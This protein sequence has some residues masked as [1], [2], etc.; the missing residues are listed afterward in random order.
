M[1]C[2]SHTANRLC[3]ALPPD[4]PT[5]TAPFDSPFYQKA[6]PCPAGATG[7]T[8]ST[9]GHTYGWDAARRHSCSFDKP[10]A[11]PLPAGAA[12]LAAPAPRRGGMR[13]SSPRPA[14]NMHMLSMQLP[15]VK[16]LARLAP[17]ANPQAA[18]ALIAAPALSMPAGKTQPLL[19]ARPLDASGA[20]GG[21][22]TGVSLMPPV[23]EPLEPLQTLRRTVAAPLPTAAAPVPRAVTLPAASPLAGPLKPS[24]WDTPVPDV[25]HGAGGPAHPRPSAP[26]AD[27]IAAEQPAELQPATMATGIMSVAR[28]QAVAA[29]AVA[30]ATG[31]AA[32]ILRAVDNQV[33]RGLG[34]ASRAPCADGPVHVHVFNRSLCACVL[35]LQAGC[36]YWP[37]ECWCKPAEKCMARMLHRSFC[38]P[39]RISHVLNRCC[40][41]PAQVRKALSGHA[42]RNATGGATH[43]G[44]AAAHSNATATPNSAAAA[45]NSAAVAAGEGAAKEA[46]DVGSGGGSGA[47]EG[48]V[49][50]KATA[51]DGG[52]EGPASTS[53]ADSG[54]G[55]LSRS[56]GAAA[57]AKGRDATAALSANDVAA[58]PAAPAA[59]AVMV[60][61][62][63]QT[64]ASGR[65]RPSWAASQAE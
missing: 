47:A 43:A 23:A 60:M 7:P 15:A 24:I 2:A 50:L 4:V 32:K 41:S 40:H 17:G 27:F 16:P 56:A 14:I 61:G 19:A 63:P 65:P 55:A 35:R 33:G 12:P 18:A 64:A 13:E 46:A 37:T 53:G 30:E 48:E 25:L 28:A 9:D 6:P 21:K 54:G 42:A 34:Q 1:L 58:E 38:I 57:P 52:K 31:E 10:G 8:K 11:A 3:R 39:P 51:L 20:L 26:V 49:N 45:P 29:S 62:G 36:S 5:Q 22:H 44:A 59:K